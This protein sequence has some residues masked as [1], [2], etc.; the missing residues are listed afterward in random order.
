M[1]ARLPSGLNGCIS[2]GQGPEGNTA[3]LAA[4]WVTF[5]TLTRPFGRQI[6]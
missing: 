1:Y 3:W 4:F 2:K 6:F 5:S